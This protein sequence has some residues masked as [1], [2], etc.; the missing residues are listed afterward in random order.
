VA[1]PVNLRDLGGYSA[2]VGTTR[3]GVLMRSDAPVGLDPAGIEALRRLQIRTAIDLREPIER[4]LDPVELDGLGIAV[5]SW[6]VIDGRIDLHTLK[7]L[8]HLYREILDR[9]GDRLAGTIRLLSSAAAVPAVVFCSAGKDRTGLVSALVLAAAGVGDADVASEYALTEANMH[10]EFRR[11]VE[12]RAIAAGLS[13]QALA[14][15]LGAPSGLMLELLAE[16]RE[17]H[18][19]AAGYLAKHGLGEDELGSL[20]R[21]LV[22]PAQQ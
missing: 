9:C 5:R 6:S 14:A 19:G 15:K 20:R 22:A 4:E 21:V 1:G 17:T 10:G 11:K 18:G 3:R 7:D 8:P 16:L 2:G 13:E 12:A